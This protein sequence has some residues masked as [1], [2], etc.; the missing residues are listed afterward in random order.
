MAITEF[1][2]IARYFAQVGAVRNDVVLGVGDD[3]ALLTPPPRHDL[4]VAVSTLVEGP[5]FPAGTAPGRLAYQAL[6]VA[7]SH[8][9]AAA[10][11]PAWLTLTLCMTKANEDWLKAFSDCLDALAKGLNIRLVGGDTTEGPLRLTLHAHGFVPTGQAPEPH[12][13]RPGDLVYVTGT[14][15]NGELAMLAGQNRRQLPDEHIGGLHARLQ[16]LE[17]RIAR[18]LALRGLASGAFSRVDGLAKGLSQLLQPARSGA[19]LVAES[20]PLSPTLAR[21][22]QGADGCITAILAVRDP[23]LCFTVPP[24]GQAELESRFAELA[25]GCTCI[26]AIDERPGLRCLLTDGARLE[27]VDVPG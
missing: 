12:L 15:G 17:Q 18:G 22:L 11:E 8:L 16:Q 10:S 20:L 1:S 14:L 3:A 2:L 13:I 7:L 24:A 26:G 21:N 5:D 27:I 4:A 19:S 23:E 9:S 25:E 6:A